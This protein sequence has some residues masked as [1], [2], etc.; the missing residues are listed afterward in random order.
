MVNPAF[1]GYHLIR[2]VV[3]FDRF[4]DGFNLYTVKVFVKAIKNIAKELR[5]I[6]LLITTELK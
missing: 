5:G 3:A 1:L 6:V 4:Y 2:A